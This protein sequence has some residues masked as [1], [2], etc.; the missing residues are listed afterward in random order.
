MKNWSRVAPRLASAFFVVIMVETLVTSSRC[1]TANDRLERYVP[2][3]WRTI[4]RQYQPPQIEIQLLKSHV[5]P[6]KKIESSIEYIFSSNDYARPVET[7][8]S[9]E[10]PQESNRG[11]ETTTES[12]LIPKS[13]F[14]TITKFN[15][16]PAGQ[17]KDQLGKCREI[18]GK[19]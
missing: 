6:D 5:S 10:K 16:C 17:A 14:D 12:S 19:K 18:F 13:I 1:E 2:D 11:R 9:E 4:P 15:P 7:Q 3:Q 8:S